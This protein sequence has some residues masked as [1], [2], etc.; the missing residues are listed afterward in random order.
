MG[1]T[2][3]SMS[4]PSDL[5]SQDMA[6]G[7]VKL[8]LHEIYL[9]FFLSIMTRF[10]VSNEMLKWLEITSSVLPDLE[11]VFCFPLFSHVQCSFIS[12]RNNL[13]SVYFCLPVRKGIWDSWVGICVAAEE[14]TCAQLYTYTLLE[15]SWKIPKL[16]RW[17]LLC[18][19]VAKQGLKPNR[20]TH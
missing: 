6:D 19:T 2:C 16:T 9:F 3:G 11:E 5:K 8:W 15:N 12:A 4:Q 18:P 14:E 1:S 20:L 7:V 17:M 10:V 13:K